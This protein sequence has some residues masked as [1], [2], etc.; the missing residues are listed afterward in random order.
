M[1][2]FSDIFGE[3]RKIYLKGKGFT[4]RQFGLAC[5]T[6]A[7]D[8]SVGFIEEHLFS[9]S[10]VIDSSLHARL[11]DNP[12]VIQLYVVPFTLACY[13]MVVLSADN[14]DKEVANEFREGVVEGVR[15]LPFD[16]NAAEAV[17]SMWQLLGAQMSESFGDKGDNGGLGFKFP[18][19]ETV[20]GLLFDGLSNMERYESPLEV[21]EL[22]KVAISTIFSTKFAATFE[23]FNELGFRIA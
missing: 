14:I 3:R 12:A 8:D 6:W 21:D 15:A 10:E 9:V 2:F 17:Y 4:P 22:E 7:L 1:G 13:T 23:S 19:S 11:T 16:G 5:V 20:S 18:A